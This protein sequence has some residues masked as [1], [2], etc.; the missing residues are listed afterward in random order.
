MEPA[1]QGQIGLAPSSDNIKLEVMRTNETKPKKTRRGSPKR[2]QVS[3]VRSSDR[4]LDRKIK[5]LIEER[6]KEK[7]DDSKSEPMFAGKNEDEKRLKR[8]LKR[9]LLSSRTTGRCLAADIGERRDIERK[10]G[11]IHDEKTDS[12]SR[13]CRDMAADVA[14]GHQC[15]ACKRRFKYDALLK[16]HRS[17]R[18]ETFNYAMARRDGAS[19]GAGIPIGV[20]NESGRIECAKCSRTF[21]LRNRYRAHY[22][23][24]HRIRGAMAPASKKTQRQRRGAIN[25][26]AAP[27][28]CR[29]CRRAFAHLNILK[30][31]S[32]SYHGS[33]DW[34]EAMEPVASPPARTN[35]DE[36]TTRSASRVKKAPSSRKNSSIKCPQCASRFP[37][38]ACVSDHLRTSHDIATLAYAREPFALACP[39]CPRLEESSGNRD[40]SVNARAYRDFEQH[41]FD[42]HSVDLSRQCYVCGESYQTR[43]GLWRHLDCRHR[44][45]SRVLRYLPVHRKYIA[46]PGATAVKTEMKFDDIK[47]ENLKCHYCDEVYPREESLFEHLQ[48]THGQ[49]ASFAYIDLSASGAGDRYKYE[50][51]RCHRV[52]VDCRVMQLH[53]VEEH[54]LGKRNRGRARDAIRG[55]FRCREDQCAFE[56]KLDSE[57]NL[58]MVLV[59]PAVKYDCPH[60]QYSARLFYQLTDHLPKHGVKY[61][62]N[63]CNKECRK[64]F[65]LK[66]HKFKK[67]GI[68][69][70]SLKLLEC[71]EPGCHYTCFQK[72]SLKAHKIK[73]Q[74]DKPFVC[75]ECG[76]CLKTRQSL[77]MHV[78]KVHKRIRPYMCEICGHSFARKCEI[79]AHV[80]Q[81]TTEKL[82]CDHCNY[83]TMNKYS[84]ISHMLSRHNIQVRENERLYHCPMCDYKTMREKHL[85]NHINSHLNVRNFTCADCGKSFVSANSLRG[86]TNWVHSEKRYRCE[87]CSYRGGSLSNLKQHVRIMHTQRG[88]KPYKCAYCDFRCELSGNCRVHCRSAHKGMA[89]K[90]VKVV[91]FNLDL[92]KSSSRTEVDEGG[93]APAATISAPQALIGDVAGPL[94]VP[95]REDGQPL[96]LP[97]ETVSALEEARLKTKERMLDDE[98]DEL[99]IGAEPTSSQ[100]ASSEGDA[101]ILLPAEIISGEELAAGD[102]Y[103]FVRKSRSDVTDDDITVQIRNLGAD[104]VTVHVSELSSQFDGVS[105]GAVK[106]LDDVA[107]LTA[108]TRQLMASHNL[109]VIHDMQQQQQPPLGIDQIGIDETSSAGSSRAGFPA[110]L[111]VAQLESAMANA[112]EN[113]R[114]QA[115]I[116][117]CP[118]AISLDVLQRLQFASQS[119]D[120]DTRDPREEIHGQYVHML[121]TNQMQYYTVNNQPP[122]NHNIGENEFSRDPAQL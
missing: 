10:E 23:V 4:I 17:K 101:V 106:S 54:S 74:R 46:S 45:K 117:D 96:T 77:V 18:H 38:H 115:Q 82:Q 91:D 107:G 15:S 14:S 35:S 118:R 49:Y 32:R 34:F 61:P 51:L 57:L 11:K 89:I 113:G 5:T 8:K 71:E 42:E 108:T 13:R 111:F 103:E 116:L 97:A 20:K 56:S 69:D 22:V 84:M 85:T 50:C 90:W 67:H 48:T 16:L 94:P 68:K 86:H 98:S 102:G 73:H 121:Q 114:V 40:E 41:L 105:P 43:R 104:G 122:V 52:F 110:D 29:F 64:Q 31:H 65:A 19:G 7:S 87:F 39:R 36:I 53:F 55:V 99:T 62:C 83:N 26:K 66:R 75:Q 93:D 6:E 33:I 60:C 30:N 63:I 25:V 24:E 59:H 79:R 9:L 3:A 76:R 81:H 72:C 21:D 95:K 47:R 100:S 88:L 44:H 109:V 78:D 37:T 92:P 27:Y 120:E 58:H 80:R 28:K 2:H 70:S 119:P 12:T 1:I 112:S